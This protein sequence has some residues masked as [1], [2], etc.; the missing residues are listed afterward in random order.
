M[1]VQKVVGKPD[2]V[3]KR[4]EGDEQCAFVD[5]PVCQRQVEELQSL[6]KGSQCTDWNLCCII[7][8]TRRNQ[9]EFAVSHLS[10]KPGTPNHL[11]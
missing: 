9:N 8:V 2:K 10:S 1:Q 5:F 4:L 3:Q 7:I 6:I 11:D